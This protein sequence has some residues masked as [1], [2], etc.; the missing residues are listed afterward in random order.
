MGIGEF[1][2]NLT[3]RSSIQVARL[4]FLLKGEEFEP[5]LMDDLYSL[6]VPTLSNL[7][8][9][10]PVS[11]PSMPIPK[12]QI[13]LMMD[14]RLIRNKIF[15][16]APSWQEVR[17]TVDAIAV[18]RALTEWSRRWNLNAE[19]CLD[20][21]LMAVWLY[22][23]PLH[24]RFVLGTEMSNPYM[25]DGHY[26]NAFSD[27]AL[28]RELLVGRKRTSY[29]QEQN[30]W[31]MLLSKFDGRPKGFFRPPGFRAYDTEP[32]PPE[33]WP[34]WDSTQ[35]PRESY[36]SRVGKESLEAIGKN[37]F[38][39]AG[40][41]QRKRG[42]VSSVL[43][44]ANSYCDKVEKAQR[45]RGLRRVRFSK[46]IKRNLLW[47]VE[48]QILGK[49][50]TAIANDYS[51]QQ[52]QKAGDETTAEINI[53]TV[54]RAVEN[55]LKFIGLEKRPDSGPGRKRGTFDAAQARITRQLGR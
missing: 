54:K 13:Q 33:G 52:A 9:P 11:S 37:P 28:L 5:E 21:A 6:G 17:T 55:T 4:Y 15:F 53:T 36:L 40:H 35:E 48:F 18:Y 1:E 10:A 46:N 12:M 25:W 16:R 49:T 8:Y 26:A 24:R 50:Y 7:F 47:S 30:D 22:C 42:L 27:W 19:W 45:S 39:S 44:I 3:N 34:K 41:L 14:S 32:R 2:A 43:E 20:Y 38:L 23:Y 31:Q 51:L 29:K